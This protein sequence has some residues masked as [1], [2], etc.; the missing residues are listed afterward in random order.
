MFTHPFTD[1]NKR[2]ALAAADVQLRLN[3]YHLSVDPDEGHTFIIGRLTSGEFEFAT[4]EPWLREH[5][6]GP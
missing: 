3:G 4:I 5:T 6:T 1:G 2:V